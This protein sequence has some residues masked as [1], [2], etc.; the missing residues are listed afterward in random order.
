VPYGFLLDFST[1]S[2]STGFNLH[3]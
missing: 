2:S 3:L 1:M